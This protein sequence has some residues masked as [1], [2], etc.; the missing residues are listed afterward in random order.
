[1]N[2]T[3]STWVLLRGLTR[4]AAHWGDFVPALQAALPQARLLCVDLPGA[5]TAHRQACPP[6]IPAIAAHC[7]AAAQ[8][9]GATG[10]LGLL[11]LSMGGMVAADWLLRHPSEVQTAVLVNSSVAGLS[12]LHHRLRP[13][14]WPRLP[15]LALGWGS[16]AAEAQV[17]GLSSRRRPLPPDWLAHWTA[18]QRQRPVGR[19]NA[20]RQ[21]WAAARYRLPPG[22]PAM[23][24]LVLRSLGDA[25]VAP[26]CSAALARH[27]DC[28]LWEHPR[29][30]HDL[31][32]DDPQWL[33]Q[34]VARWT[35]CA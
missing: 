15:A 24:V 11:G 29:A 1:M 18:I 9:A 17:L 7:R 13:G 10:P 35:A 28:P 31:A 5:G 23:P 33:A 22:R 34:A 2:A 8:A 21:L 30:G 32:L 20:L 4:E 26:A 27:W 19:G 6:T 25:M 14:H 3:P 12:P 16:A